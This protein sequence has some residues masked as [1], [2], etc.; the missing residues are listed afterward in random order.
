MYRAREMRLT[1][2]RKSEKQWT[3]EGRYDDDEE[4][5]CFRGLE[6]KSIK[7]A[8]QRK[9]AKHSALCAVLSAQTM[10]LRQLLDGNLDWAPIREAYQTV[11]SECQN[12]AHEAGLADGM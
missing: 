2:K 7:G 4:N 8:K 10:Q 5:V 1:P 6:H 3:E 12:L 11:S 9:Q